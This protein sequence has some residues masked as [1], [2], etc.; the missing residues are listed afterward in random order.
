[1]PV[2]LSQGLDFLKYFSYILI[3]RITSGINKVLRK[4]NMNY[5]DINMLSGYIHYSVRSIYKMVETDRIPFLKVNNRLRFSRQQVDTWMLNN[6]QMMD[7][8]DLPEL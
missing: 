7:L 3:T 6:G 5:M 8:P 1:M 4:I 2:K